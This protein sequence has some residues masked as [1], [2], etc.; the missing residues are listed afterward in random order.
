MLPKSIRLMTLRLLVLF[1]PFNTGY[2]YMGTVGYD[3]VFVLDALLFILYMDWFVR[4][5]SGRRTKFFF[6]KTATPGV[7]MILWA[8]LSMI[9]AISIQATMFATIMVIKAV[10]F[11]LYFVNNINTRKELKLI[12]FFLLVG[13][14]FQDGLALYQRIAKHSLGLQFLGEWQRTYHYDLAR[15]SGT[16][17]FPNHLGCYMVL[18]VWFSIASFL[19]YKKNKY[20]TLHLPLIGI[21]L[22]AIILTFTRAT[23][24]GLAVSGLIVFLLLTGRRGL[25][26][27]LVGTAVVL[28]LVSTIAFLP[29]RSL[30]FERIEAGGDPYRVIMINIAID[31]IK[32]NPILGVG[33]FNFEY[34][35]YAV[36]SFWKPV[37]NTYLRLGAETG[38]P[39]L[40][41]FLW[42]IVLVFKTAG[43][44]TRIN[45]GFLRSIGY[46][47]IGA[48]VGFCAIVNIG[49]EYAMYRLKVLFWIIGALPYCAIRVRNN[50]ILLKRKKQKIRDQLAASQTDSDVKVPETL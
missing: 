27:N 31:M 35:S 21:T 46:A 42:Y 50:E 44:A 49:P 32:A 13:L 26:M 14:A 24:F 18:T 20:R 38:L 8:A 41:F 15:I 17:G 19:V 43:K 10:L 1:I 11:H 28:L 25:T 34:N 2:F 16:F 6:P 33:L 4:S 29:L 7:L 47:V 39:G 5:Y 22:V 37:H 12:V 40:A 23:W 45:D 9:M 3:M 30:I 48:Y 36:F